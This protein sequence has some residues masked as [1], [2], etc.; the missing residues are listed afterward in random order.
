M[1]VLK[2]PFP[3]SFS[4]TLLSSFKGLSQQETKNKENK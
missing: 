3:I 4:K 1:V 2:I